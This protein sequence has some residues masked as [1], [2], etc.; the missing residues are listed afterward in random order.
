MLQ[1]IIH[2]CRK[3]TERDDATRIANRLD[4]NKRPG[5]RLADVGHELPHLIAEVLSPEL[6]AHTRVHVRRGDE[7]EEVM[8]S[9][10]DRPYISITQ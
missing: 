7:L 8:V 4:L 2:P 10:N 1:L 9:R 5:C 6:L 3:S